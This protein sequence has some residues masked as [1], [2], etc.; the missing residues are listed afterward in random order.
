MYPIYRYPPG[1]ILK[2]LRDFILLRPRCFID[3]SKIC[4]ANNN[5]SISMLGME[6][7]P[8]NR[9]YL[10]TLNHYCRPGFQVW[11]LVIA[12]VTFLPRDAHLIMTGELT[13]WY[14]V[15]GN[16]LSRFALPRLAK[17]YGFTTMPPMPPRP[18]DVQARAKSVRQVLK[19]VNMAVRPVLVFA[20]EG[21]D[22]LDGGKLA[23]PPEGAGRFMSLL[24][25]KGLVVIP[26]AGWEQDGQL[27]VRFGAGYEL[28]SLR[29][30]SSEERDRAA[31]V[32]VMQAIARLLPEYLRGVFSDSQGRGENL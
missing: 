8:K 22:N 11:W 21:R 26:V 18:K 13:R 23:W 10:V 16:S 7:I 6:N 28:P 25:S 12:I 5:K 30:S 29:G 27:C 19:Y 31:S 4:V 14:G 2:L 15:L 20:P 9:P 1:L 17:M 24:A 3:D 32:I